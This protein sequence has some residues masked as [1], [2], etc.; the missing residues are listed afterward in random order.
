MKSLCE[1]DE[2]DELGDHV[3]WMTIV[4]SIAL[5]LLKRLM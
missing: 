3:N 1:L 2:F 4:S 5:I